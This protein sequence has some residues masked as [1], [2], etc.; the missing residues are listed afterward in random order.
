MLTDTRANIRALVARRTRIVD[1]GNAHPTAS[2]NIDI[3]D[4]Y[5][6]AR[7][8]AAESGWDTYLKTTGQLSLPIV[9]AT[10]ETFVE[11]PV[12]TDVRFIKRLETRDDTGTCEWLDAD[13][14]PLAQLR[15]Q[16]QGY[17][18]LVHTHRKR[19]CLLDEGLEATE[20]GNTG[21]AV[22]GR[23]A[24]SPVPTTGYYQLWYVPQFPGTTADS[25]AG[26]FYVYCNDMMRQ[27]HVYLASEKLIISDND[28]N[29]MLEGIL[30]KRQE[31]EA[32]LRGSRPV[33]AGPR[34]WRRSRQYYG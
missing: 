29:G 14:V 13:E 4:A 2:L 11:I 25:G 26:G 10:N 8:I 7:D 31:Y 21:S 1:R 5:Q 33:R 22:A 24:L 23:I 17:S 16:V 3:D 12:P 19:W 18:R 6:E 20:A 9:A 32:K 34:T 15:S 30:K 27:L 28:S